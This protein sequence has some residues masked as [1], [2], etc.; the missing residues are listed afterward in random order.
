MLLFNSG[1]NPWF[2]VVPGA[3]QHPCIST[4]APRPMLAYRTAG[5]MGAELPLHQLNP[6]GARAVLGGWQGGTGWRVGGTGQADPG[7]GGVC[8]SSD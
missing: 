3:N 2:Y 8:V 6:A 5:S 7:R 1:R 4:R